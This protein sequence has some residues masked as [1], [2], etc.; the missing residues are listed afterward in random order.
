MVAAAVVAVVVAVH[1]FSPGTLRL[2]KV[3]LCEFQDSHPEKPCLKKLK[4]NK[5][6]DIDR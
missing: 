4:Q 1:T 5:E 3:D 6:K 2:R